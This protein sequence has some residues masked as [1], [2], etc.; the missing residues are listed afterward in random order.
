MQMAIQNTAGQ[1]NKQ[2]QPIHS[3]SLWVGIELGLGS[4][5][6]RVDGDNLSVLMLSSCTSQLWCSPTIMVDGWMEYGL[7]A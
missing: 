1:K 2:T 7:F 3:F 4:S 5:Y 6:V